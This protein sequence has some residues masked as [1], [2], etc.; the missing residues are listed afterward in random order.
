[1]NIET[2]IQKGQIVEISGSIL[3]RDDQGKVHKA[4]LKKSHQTVHAD[5]SN[6]L[7]LG[8]EVEFIIK[9]DLAVIHRILPPNT[10]LLRQ[11]THN[12][13]QN[14]IIACNLD[15]AMVIIA[16][17]YPLT[18]IGM[19]D[20]MLIACTSGKVH[21]ILVINKNDEEEDLHPEINSIYSSL[22]IPL[23]LVS[24]K[25]SEGIEDLK[26]LLKGK[27]TIFLG[28]SG[29]GKSSLIRCLTGID[30]R[31]NQLNEIGKSGRHTTSSSKLYELDKDTFVADVPGIKELGFLQLDSV[32]SFFPEIMKMIPLCK[33]SNC[34]HSSEP[35]C[36]VIDALQKGQIHPKRFASYQ[37]LIKERVSSW[38]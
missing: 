13:R 24:A 17:N 33:Y 19:I 6:S 35:S 22:N 20:R 25:N 26:V 3:L 30:L 11:S 14:Q 37:K 38:E 15:Q 18:P 32:A 23:Y 27:K 29:V 21:P 2:E 8:D 16:K 10:I 34:T 12:S 28:L 31:V 7:A 1:M 9:D 36:A 4:W 5:K